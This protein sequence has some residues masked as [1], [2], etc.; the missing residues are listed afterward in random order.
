MVI[1]RRHQLEEAAVQIVTIGDQT[2]LAF[3]TDGTKTIPIYHHEVVLA[4]AHV[5]STGIICPA[6]STA[7]FHLT[8]TEWIVTGDIRFELVCYHTEDV[9][10]TIEDVQIPADTEADSTWF[11]EDMDLL[12][13]AII[14]H[15]KKYSTL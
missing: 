13:Q 7:V 12:L 15:S 8:E 14:F 6:F 2:N 10:V 9:P 1:M 4:G 11:F 3:K 5:I